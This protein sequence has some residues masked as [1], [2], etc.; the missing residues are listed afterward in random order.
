MRNLIFKTAFL[1]AALFAFQPA[2]SASTPLD[3]KEVQEIKDF[4]SLKNKKGNLLTPP[5]GKISQGAKDIRDLVNKIVQNIAGKDLADK[6]INLVINVYANNVINAWVQQLDPAVEESQEFKWNEANKGQVWPL[7]KAWGFEKNA[8]SIYEIGVTT[9]LLRALKTQDQLAFILGHELTHLFE[10]HTNHSDDGNDRFKGWWSSQSHEVVADHMGADRI[11]GKYELDGALEV[12]DILHPK[13]KRQAKPSDAFGEFTSTHHSEG[14]R[15]SALQY[16]IEYFRRYDEKA[17]PIKSQ[18]LPDTVKLLVHGRSEKEVPEAGK[19]EA[20]QKYLEI[21]RTMLDGTFDDAGLLQKERDYANPDR[22]RSLEGLLGDEILSY[23]KLVIDALDLAENAQVS[24][25][26]KVNTVLKA[27][28]FVGSRS[29]SYKMDA[30]DPWFKQ[31]SDIEMRRLMGFFLVNSSG[32]NAWSKAAFTQLKGSAL[33]HLQIPFFGNLKGQKSIERLATLS[34]VWKEFLNYSMSMA[35]FEGPQFQTEAFAHYLSFLDPDNKIPETALT[36]NMRE[37]ILREL[38]DYPQSSRLVEPVLSYGLP[39]YT[40]IYSQSERNEWVK[41]VNKASEPHLPELNA[42]LYKL[43]I[44]GLEQGAVEIIAKSQQQESQETESA[45]SRFADKKG[46]RFVQGIENLD[47]KSLT[48]AQKAQLMTSLEKYIEA[49]LTPV[50]GDLSIMM[51]RD[52]TA[53]LIVELLNSRSGDRTKQIEIFRYLV[54][55]G[56]GEYAQESD[57]NETSKDVLRKFIRSLS[58]EEWFTLAEALTP[59]ER[60]LRLMLD[61]AMKKTHA[62]DFNALMMKR[63]KYKDQDVG[64][65]LLVWGEGVGRNAKTIHNLLHT[66]H[67]LDVAI[68]SSLVDFKRWIRDI[69]VAQRYSRFSMLGSHE[70]TSQNASLT[71]Y[72]MLVK[73]IGATKSLE[74]AANLYM[75]TKKFIGPGFSADPADEQVILDVIK[76]RLALLPL[77]QQISWLQKEPIRKVVGA[78]FTGETMATYL[79]SVAGTDRKRTQLEADRLEKAI[80]TKDQWPDANKFFR[81]SLA[82][83]MNLQPHET[84]TVFTQSAASTTEKAEVGNN[85]VRGMSGFSAYTRAMPFSEQIEMI[86]FMMGR[87]TKMPKTLREQE[88]IAGRVDIRSTLLEMR[89]EIKFRTVLDRS[90]IVNSILVGQNAMLQDPAGLKMVHDHLL[91]SVAPQNREIAETILNSL[92]AAEG[93]NKSLLL[94]YALAQLPDG[95]N[96]NQALS[97]ALVLR[98]LLD[99]YGVPGV[100]LA[101]YLAFTSEFKDF[102]SALEIYQDAA[103]PISYYDALLLLQKRLGAA[104]DPSLY[105]VNRIIGSGSVNIAIEYQNLKTDKAEVISIARDQIEIKT[106]ED[107]R[108][109]Q[110][111]IKELNNTPERR[112]KFE[113]V[114]GLLDLIQRSVTLEFDKQNSFKMQKSVQDL[115][116]QKVDGWNLQTVDAFEVMNMAIRMEK[117]P[118]SGARKIL[119]KDPKTYESAMRAFMKV[120]Y[121]AL[122]GVNEKKNWIPVTLHANPD[123][124]DGQV[125]IDVPNKTVTIL[126]FG[127]ALEISNA[128]RE[129]ALDILRIISGV[130]SPAASEKLMQKHAMALQNKKIKLDQKEL[131]E[132]LQ[133]PDRMDRFVHLLSLFNRSGFEAPLSSVHWVLAANRLIKLGEKINVSAESSFKWMLGM[134]KVG[135]PLTAYNAGKTAADKVSD[136]AKKFENPV[137]PFACR[138]VLLAR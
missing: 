109:F 110:L 103:M 19:E 129:L 107:F 83:K 21:I 52:S 9:G 86:E 3:A 79:Q 30:T 88:I 5:R 73:T 135:L 81:Q 134:R 123:V 50:K 95:D 69:E 39:A 138:R 82:E 63:I 36:K 121:A 117:A 85:F 54:L 40:Y 70:K 46:D 61:Y 18:V 94:S 76:S 32:E 13:S 105:R 137:Y 35:A 65:E 104:W 91:K 55:N 122:R 27:M 53:D 72:E 67:I 41:A 131:A 132:I 119:K 60:E 128:E 113:F 44:Q 31:F 120:E 96:P 12:M 66:V 49:S 97:E 23:K 114:T 116:R 11:L 62:K 22:D 14:V 28:I 57:F 92:A 58:N 93:R 16:Y 2:F 115:Y 99:A 127:Q 10:G 89:D 25:S 78:Q 6:K 125:M 33:H 77:K 7:R 8:D 118:G 101:Q 71:I 133:R 136:F 112:Q 106:K 26:V 130:E 24:K 84:G 98:S 17:K 102:N 80:P 45:E 20:R 56:K 47:M 42:I 43:I 38:R 90:M 4:S 64:R 108:R 126:D 75:K 68:P 59:Q 48:S 74:E 100:K 1:I 111:L 87:S 29:S 15:I 34:P 124:H 37:K 51:V